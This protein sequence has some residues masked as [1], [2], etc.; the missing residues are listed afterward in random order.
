[1]VEQ[2]VRVLARCEA[3]DHH[4]RVTGRGHTGTCPA[5]GGVLHSPEEGSDEEH[6]LEHALACH[7]CEAINPH[8]GTECTACGATLLEPLTP[9]ELEQLASGRREVAQALR[10][11][12]RRMTTVTW[13]YRG[14]ALTYALV[15]LVAILA[16]SRSDVPRTPGTLVVGL[17][18]VL[19]VVLLMGAIQIPFRPFLWTV[20]LASLAT[21]ISA[22]HLIGPN[23]LGLMFAGTVVWACVFWATLPSARGFRQLIERYTDEYVLHHASLRTRRSLGHDA[24]EQRHR[25][26][27]A[28]MRRAGARAWR[29]SAAAAVLILAASAVGTYSVLAHMRP[30]E[31]AQARTS[32]ESS[33]AAGDLAAIEGL[34]VPSLRVQEGSRLAGMTSGYGWAAALPP[35]GPGQERDDEGSIWVSYEVGDLALT[36]HWV[37]RDRRWFLAEASL[38]EPPLEPVLE[39]FIEAWNSSDLEAVAS[40]VPDGY[41]ERMHEAWML[42]AGYRDWEVLPP[43]IGTEREPAPEGAGQ[44]QVLLQLEQGQVVTTRWLFRRSGRWGLQML[45]FPER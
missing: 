43:V 11:G 33:W 29:V 39:Q 18:T 1:M 22:V 19:T 41:R 15:T 17:T 45:R 14:G 38:P 36:T 6:H 21:L 2:V 13:L 20:I 31:L 4:Y 30:Q 35:L 37:L 7:A 25:R 5:C 42:S 12:Y 24:G 40:F 26:L 44:V 8:A 34:F 28:V 9:E 3:C 27:L 32:F 10:R 23:P 16:L